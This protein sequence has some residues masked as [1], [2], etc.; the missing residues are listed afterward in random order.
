MIISSCG[1][2]S[3]VDLLKKLQTSLKSSQKTVRKLSNEVAIKVAEDLNASLVGSSKKFFVLNRSDGVDIDFANTFLR[4]AK[5]NENFFIFIT[6]A[7]EIDSKNG[8]LIIHG[9]PKDISALG[10]P[11]NKLLAGKGNGKNNRYQAKVTHL[12]KV[13]DCETLIQNYF[14]NKSE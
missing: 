4:A 6:I 13:K 1:T 7:D 12:D 8:T 11:I 5:V 9:A 2:D 3:H 14:A 10:D